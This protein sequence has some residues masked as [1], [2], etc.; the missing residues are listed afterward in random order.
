MEILDSIKE[1]RLNLKIPQENMLNGVTKS[2]YSK[3]ERGV[4]ELKFETLLRISNR[5]DMTIQELLNY[6]LRDE[7]IVFRITLNDCFDN[8]TDNSK[9]IAFLS[10]YY[11]QEKIIVETMSSK[12]LAY[13]TG[14]TTVFHEYWSEISDYSSSDL[15][16][17]VQY[18]QLKFFYTQYDYQILMNIIMYL[19]STETKKLLK[20]MYPIYESESRPFILK[21]LA[22]RAIINRI[23][24]LV[25]LQKYEEAQEIISFAE[26]NVDFEEDYFLA[27]SFEYHKNLV[28][29]FLLHNTLYIERARQVITMMRRVSKKIT[30]DTYELELNNLSENPAYYLKKTVSKYPRTP[31]I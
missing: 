2:A 28:D 3:I 31:I 23:S 26:K 15:S 4:V 5:F 1:I 14:I 27:L 13:F 11:P 10:T 24:T 30:A 16:K 22:S 20:K 12:E 6:G 19:T 7:A 29:R 8:L 17:I 25:Y 18:L 9:K 21:N